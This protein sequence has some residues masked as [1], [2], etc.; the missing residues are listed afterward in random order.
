MTYGA[1]S[2]AAEKFGAIEIVAPRPYTVGTITDTFKKYP[3]IDSKFKMTVRGKDGE[4][5]EL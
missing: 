4:S 3:K 1:G 2:V 5:I